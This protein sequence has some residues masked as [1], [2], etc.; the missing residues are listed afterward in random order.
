MVVLMFVVLFEGACGQGN[1]AD[2]DEFGCWG[3]FFMYT[4]RCVYYLDGILLTY[5]GSYQSSFQ[6]YILRLLAVVGM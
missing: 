6:F 2:D 1:S 3:G 5:V 4:Y